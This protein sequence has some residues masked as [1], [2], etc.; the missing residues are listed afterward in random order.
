MKTMINA[1][2][3]VNINYTGNFHLFNWCEVKTVTE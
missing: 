3:I 1:S 2:L